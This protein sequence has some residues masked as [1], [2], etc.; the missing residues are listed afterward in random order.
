MKCII[1][2]GGSGNRL[3]PL[4]RKNYPKQFLKVQSDHSLFQETII[5]NKPFVE[6]FLLVANE[7]FSFTILN[8]LDEIKQDR[9]EMLLE[10]NGRNTA[11]AIAM[12][13]L[14]AGLEELILVVPSDH[15]I[16]E[17]PLYNKAVEEAKVLAEQDYLVTFGI[18]ASTPQTGYGYI[19]YIGNNVLE[20]KEKPDSET[21]EAYL[22][23]GDYLWNSGMFLFRSRVLLEELKKFRPDIYESCLKVYK[24]MIKDKTELTM[25]LNAVPSES[26]DY[27]VLEKSDK[28]KVVPSDFEW[29]DVGSFEAYG[30]FVE[31]DGQENSIGQNALYRNSNNV[32]TI[33]DS[34]DKLIVVNDLSDL[35]VVNTNDT[36]YISKMGTSQNIKEI[37]VANERDE[38]YKDYFND[39]LRSHRPWGYY[40]VLLSEPAYKIKRIVIYPGRRLSLQKHE[41]RS[42]HWT[43]AEG[44]VVV[45]VG[46]ETKVLEKNQGI[47]IPLGAVHRAE[48][49]TDANIAI[50]EV[51]IGERVFE[52]DIIRFEDDYNR[53]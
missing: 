13:C 48:N 37:V 18:R 34:P 44:S 23:S 36:V 29:F 9:C 16:I 1:L 17:G 24:E 19:K 8:H 14:F 5:R 28:V 2:V 10:K 33:N 22:Q 42:E 52:E 49:T 40:E 25:D 43:I 31:K 21:A 53:V 32:L 45:T 39:N 26:I 51:G 35:V 47:Y 6:E 20:F 15:K 3:W 50:I 11:P 38:R 7:K 27:A 12:A 4:S 46:D 41:L 30:D